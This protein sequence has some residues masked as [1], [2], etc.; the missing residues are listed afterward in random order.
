MATP[1]GF[2]SQAGKH[3]HLISPDLALEKCRLKEMPKRPKEKRRLTKTFDGTRR[4]QIVADSIYIERSHEELWAVCK[5]LPSDF[6]PYGQR[7]R[8]T[9]DGETRDCSC[10]YASYHVLIGEA[11]CDWG[12]CVNPQSP[13]AG[14]LTFE[15]Q[16][17]PQFQQNGTIYQVPGNHQSLG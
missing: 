15:H 16:G 17:C 11:R 3:F 6:E 10:G 2:G 8:E 1:L 5:R 13:R 9:G 4:E 14:L 12:V 7:S